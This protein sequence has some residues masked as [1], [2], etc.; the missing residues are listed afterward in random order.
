MTQ[1]KYDKYDKAIKK[2]NPKKG[3]L[4]SVC[5]DGKWGRAAIG[6]VLQRRG[7][8]I[9][10]EFPEYAEEE[11][12]TAWFVRTS[13]TSFGAFADVKKSIMRS[14]YGLKGDWYTV[15][16]IDVYKV[17]FPNKKCKFPVH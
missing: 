7:F 1:D 11:W 3:D 5:Y 2:L 4:V 13:P 14:L 6:K 15:L 10:V 16:H 8:A 9:Q 17:M 12:L